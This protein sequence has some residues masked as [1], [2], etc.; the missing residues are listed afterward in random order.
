LIEC[1][2]A[3]GKKLNQSSSSKDLSK[4]SPE[5]ANPVTGPLFIEGAKKGQTL[6]VTV[7]RCHESEWGWTA[8]LP[9]FGLL[10]ED[11]KTPKLQISKVKREKVEFL[12][13]LGVAPGDGK[14]YSMIP[15]RNFGGNMDCSHLLEGSKVYLPIF[16]DGALFSIGDTHAV[17]GD[18]EVCGT[19]VESPFSVEC[20]FRVLNQELL[21]P[22]FEI[23]SRESFD[24]LS[25]EGFWMSSG[26]GED[27]MS[28]SKDAVRRMI[29]HLSQTLGLSE[30]KAYMLCSVIGDLGVAEVVDEPNWM[31][32]FRMPKAL[33]K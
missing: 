21:T 20:S 1:L 14:S 32:T 27:L 3:S 17:Q 13:G 19:A 7:H 26:I 22:F 8:I 6:E 30:E 11:F 29:E 28:C 2:E 4:L 18:G 23:P 10:Q 15:P 9:D 24:E 25:K 12:P 33:F 16:Q 5:T 31:M